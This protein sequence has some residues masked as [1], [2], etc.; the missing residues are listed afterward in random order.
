MKI[1]IILI[2]ILLKIILLFTDLMDKFE[3]KLNNDIFQK[4]NTA[5]EWTDINCAMTELKDT[6]LKYSNTLNFSKISN[7]EQLAKRLAQGLN[8]TLPGG[9][10]ETTLMVYDILLENIRVI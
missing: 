10:H 7:K 3:Y 2:I 4:F 9:L 8:S 6:L 1:I 5:Q